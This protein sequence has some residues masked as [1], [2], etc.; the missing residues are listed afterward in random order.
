MALHN[1]LT[2]LLC[3]NTTRLQ[4]SLHS[5][6]THR[7]TGAQQFEYAT[8]ATVQPVAAA[9]DP[10]VCSVPTTCPT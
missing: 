3:L 7:V 4:T 2:G 9:A 1:Y 5:S 6:S 10:A 8:A